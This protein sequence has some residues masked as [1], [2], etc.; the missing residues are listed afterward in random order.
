MP[1]EAEDATEGLA[2]KGVEAPPQDL[3]RPLFGYQMGEDEPRKTDHP[4]EKPARCT[5]QMKREV[6]GPRS[7]HAPSIPA[8]VEIAHGPSLW[9]P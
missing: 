5:A 4:F 3:A 2:P 9:S 6:C 1:V 7:L 8:W